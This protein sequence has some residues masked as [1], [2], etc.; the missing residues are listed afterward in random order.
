MCRVKI[1][2]WAPNQSHHVTAVTGGLPIRAQH[3]THEGTLAQHVGAQS[4]HSQSAHS[5][6][7]PMMLALAML[8][9]WGRFIANR[10]ARANAKPP[11]HLLGLLT[12]PDPAR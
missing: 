8:L 9:L 2:K 1:T 6:T 10:S 3:R 4:A 5:G 12:A 11:L 7:P